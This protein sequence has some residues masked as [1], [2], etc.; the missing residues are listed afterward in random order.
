MHS[1]T[2]VILNTKKRVTP[3]ETQV[4]YITR[5][6]MQTSDMD[7]YPIWVQL[8]FSKHIIYFEDPRTS[9]PHIHG[10]NMGTSQKMEVQET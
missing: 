10:S 1:G 9:Y 8:D 4:I 7:M 6:W 3:T 5:T 2:V